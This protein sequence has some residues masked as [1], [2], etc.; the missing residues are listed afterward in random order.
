MD[1]LK[2]HDTKF[3]GS[4][5]SEICTE[6]LVPASRGFGKREGTMPLRLL[7][8]EM[9]RL[10]SWA[11]VVATCN[12]PPQLLHWRLRICSLDIPGLS[13]KRYTIIVPYASSQDITSGSLN[14]SF[15][16]GALAQGAMARATKVEVETYIFYSSGSIFMML[17]SL[18]YLNMQD[19][20]PWSTTIRLQVA[21]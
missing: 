2:P 3:L 16:S 19:V 13:Q 14:P 1:F 12:H 7:V 18:A 10:L 11:E 20:T 5:C 9:P 6:W 17:V 21:S 15:T 8:A 4:A